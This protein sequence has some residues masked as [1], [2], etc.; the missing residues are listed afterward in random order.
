MIVGAL[1]CFFRNYRKEPA[2]PPL[3]IAEMEENQGPGPG[4]YYG[5]STQTPFG[6]GAAYT[7][8]QKEPEAT[9]RDVGARLGREYD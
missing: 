3:P 1:F 4:D 7:P 5:A 9:P 2:D 8:L 6:N